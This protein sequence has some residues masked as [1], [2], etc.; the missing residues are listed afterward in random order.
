MTDK[1][2][3]WTYWVP[4]I[5]YAGI[6]FTLSSFPLALPP[7][8]QVRNVDK[9]IHMMEYGIFGYLLARAFLEASSSE[10]QKSFQMWAMI[11]AICY[12]FTDEIHQSFVPMR[13][14]SSIDLVCDGI[15]AI[16]AQF[17]FK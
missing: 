10:L 12:G 13:E 1:N 14:T 3:F 15:G 9:L 5:L 17:F 8:L 2:P 11:I 16:L 4:V 7:G 6:I